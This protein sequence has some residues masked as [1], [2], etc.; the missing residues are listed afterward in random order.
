MNFHLLKCAAFSH[1]ISE[2]SFWIILRGRFWVSNE[3]S[4]EGAM[5]TSL[6][7]VKFPLYDILP[8][9]WPNFNQIFTA[10]FV[11]CITSFYCNQLQTWSDWNCLLNIFSS[12]FHFIYCI[13]ALNCIQMWWRITKPIGLQHEHD[14]LPSY[15]FNDPI[16]PHKH[17]L[18]MACMNQS[19]GNL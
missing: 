17:R 13:F 6:V 19:I 18:G 10:P 9:I 15:S 1:Q 2:T 12:F 14:N 11:F 3:Q 4:L 5:Y 16:N 8:Y 7:W